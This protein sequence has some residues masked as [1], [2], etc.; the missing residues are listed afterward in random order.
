MHISFLGGNDYL[1]AG[2][3]FILLPFLLS[4]FINSSGSRVFAIFGCSAV[5]GEETFFL[6]PLRRCHLRP[7]GNLGVLFAPL[8]SP[9]I[10]IMFRFSLM[11]SEFIY[12]FYQWKKRCFSLLSCTVVFYNSNI[13]TSRY[14]FWLPRDQVVIN[15][16]FSS[17]ELL[18]S[19]GVNLISTLLLYLIILGITVQLALFGALRLLDIL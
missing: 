7:S 15:V 5:F 13:F 17:F 16:D 19:T 10:L 14:E 3:L 6:I 8:Q 11:N 12:I 2:L 18:R 9:G 4:T 1:R